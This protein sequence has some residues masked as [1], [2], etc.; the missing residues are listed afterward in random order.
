MVKV[1]LAGATKAFTDFRYKREFIGDRDMILEFETRVGSPTG[2][3]LHGVDVLTLNEQG[4][5]TEFAVLG[6]PLNAVQRLFEL[7]TKFLESVLKAK[8]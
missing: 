5:I 1:I 4:L 8:L 3:I 6:R 2:P 7:Q